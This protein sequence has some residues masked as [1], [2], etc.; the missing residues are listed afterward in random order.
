[1]INCPGCG[2]LASST[3]AADVLPDGRKRYVK[4]KNCGH[5]WTTMEITTDEYQRLRKLNGLDALICIREEL[6][7]ILAESAK[8]EEALTAANR[9]LFDMSREN[10]KLKEDN[11]QLDITVRKLL[12][13]KAREAERKAARMGVTWI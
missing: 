8:K 4:C 10:R 13:E 3:Y 11:L 7:E 12:D 1:M 6:T 2:E 5:H 9:E